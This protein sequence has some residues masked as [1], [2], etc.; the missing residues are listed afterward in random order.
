MLL[1]QTKQKTASP[2]QEWNS[3]K[4]KKLNFCRHSVG[5]NFIGNGKCIVVPIKEQEWRIHTDMYL[6]C[7]SASDGLIC[8]DG[9]LEIILPCDI[10]A[11]VCVS[12]LY[13]VHTIE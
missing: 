1:K 5:H 3:K 12:M 4:A 11:L 13:D 6:N 9:P 8:N 2:N 10:I 7:V